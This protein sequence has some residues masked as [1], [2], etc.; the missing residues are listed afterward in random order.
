MSHKHYLNRVTSELKEVVD[1]QQHAASVAFPP[2]GLILNRSFWDGI[3]LALLQRI[4]LWLENFIGRK[5][6]VENVLGQWSGINPATRVALQRLVAGGLIKHWTV[7]VP[8]QTKSYIVNATLDLYYTNPDLGSGTKRLFTS[9]VGFGGDMNQALSDA[10]AEC[11]K[12]LAVCEFKKGVFFSAKTEQLRRQNMLF[13]ATQKN[14]ADQDHCLWVRG[15]SLTQRRP[16]LLPAPMVYSTTFDGQHAIPQPANF[17]GIGASSS[18]SKSLV[19]G[20]LELLALDAFLMVWKNKTPLEGIDLQSIESSNLQSLITGIHAQNLKLEVY[21]CKSR[22][23]IPV[24]VSLISGSQYR[25]TALVGLGC[26]FDL[27]RAL[28]KSLLQAAR[29]AQFFDPP[30]STQIKQVSS[31]GADLKSATERYV[32]WCNPEHQRYLSFLRGGTSISFNSFVHEFDSLSG[33]VDAQTQLSELCKRGIQND[34]NIF[35]AEITSNRAR[36]EGLV[37]ERVLIPELMPMYFDERSYLLES[38]LE[39]IGT[40]SHVPHPFIP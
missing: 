10:V 1:I 21:T 19:L 22:L 14:T 12:K 35:S 17:F 33:Y 11:H 18:S 8:T 5:I 29:K 38:G 40:D 25:S 39:K 30:D 6:Y 26:E 36:H 7:D 28:S 13:F 4:L 34:I 32:W 9:G 24:I 31:R 15:R 16:C 3:K 37:I 27:S 23:G 20:I 2:R